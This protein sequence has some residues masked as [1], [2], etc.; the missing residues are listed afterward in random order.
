MERVP[1]ITETYGNS[2]GDC[3]IVITK[4]LTIQEAIRAVMHLAMPDIG[5]NDSHVAIKFILGSHAPKQT[6]NLI[7]T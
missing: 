7:G 3:P 2:I 4:I 6:R 1:K 5:E